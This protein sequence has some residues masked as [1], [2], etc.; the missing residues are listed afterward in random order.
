M[1]AVCVEQATHSAVRLTHQA[2]SV[3]GKQQRAYAYANAH[4]RPHKL[5]LQFTLIPS[6]VPGTTIPTAMVHRIASIA[7]ILIHISN[8][9]LCVCVHAFVCVISPHANDW[10]HCASMITEER[11]YGHSF[12]VLFLLHINVIFS[13]T[14][15]ARLCCTRYIF[16]GVCCK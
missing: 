12:L 6:V 13:R 15:L 9:C 7:Y 10:K 1:D 5:W 4:T 16:S 2:V 11:K 3:D 8:V 14:H